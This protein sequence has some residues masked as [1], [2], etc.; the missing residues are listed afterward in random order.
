MIGVSEIES[1]GLSNG[2]KVASYIETGVRQDP[3]FQANMARS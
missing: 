1:Q 3:L 2:T